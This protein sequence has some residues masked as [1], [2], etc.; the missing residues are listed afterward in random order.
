[1]VES[2]RFTLHRIF[3]LDYASMVTPKYLHLTP[4][5]VRPGVMA[6]PFRAVLI[7]EQAVSDDWRNDVAAWLV[8]NGC[9]YFIAWGLD[10]E[11]WHDSVDW[12]VLEDFDFGDIPDDR[13]VMTTWHD[14]EPLSEALWFAGNAATHPD[15]ELD[16][17]LLVHVAPQPASARIMDAYSISQALPSEG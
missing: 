16:A 1:L 13:F 4:G 14:K 7:A 17:T 9:L 2:G 10:C 3:A 11:L 5:G 15:V 8:D 12:A 6:G